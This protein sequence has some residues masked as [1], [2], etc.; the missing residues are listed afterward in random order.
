MFI[1]V[2]YPMMWW[3]SDPR[4]LQ[5]TAAIVIEVIYDVLSP[6]SRLSITSFCRQIRQYVCYVSLNFTFIF[7]SQKIVKLFQINLT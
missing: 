6:A 4:A 7:W 5:L 2:I 3:L 1:R